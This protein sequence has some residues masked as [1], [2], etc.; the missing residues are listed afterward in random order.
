MDINGVYEAGYPLTQLPL[1]FGMALTM[2]EAA[3]NRYSELSETEREHLIMRCKDARSKDEM[4]KIV[5]SI[6]PDGSAE[7]LMADTEEASRMKKEA[8]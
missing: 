7:A 8:Y 2:N 6:L 5:N 4:Q 3:M 1:G